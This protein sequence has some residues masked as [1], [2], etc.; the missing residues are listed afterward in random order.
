M[1][2]NYRSVIE[3]SRSIIGYSSVKLQLV[4]SLKIVNYDHHIFI[5]Q[6]SGRL[7]SN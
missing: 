6:A 7:R 3:D 5:V 1:I 4:A 2:D